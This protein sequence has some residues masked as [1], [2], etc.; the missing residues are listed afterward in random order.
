MLRSR[1]VTEQDHGPIR[2]SSRLGGILKQK[3]SNRQ[4][5]SLFLGKQNRV[6]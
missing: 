6:E 5:K 1:S 3:A 2:K 4:E